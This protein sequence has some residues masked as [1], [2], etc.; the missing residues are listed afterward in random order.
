MSH[1]HFPELKAPG[2]F[3][4]AC[5]KKCSVMVTPGEENRRPEYDGGQ[6]NH[7]WVKSF[8]EYYLKKRRGDNLKLQSSA[9]HRDFETFFSWNGQETADTYNPTPSR[10]VAMI[11]TEV[12]R[13]LAMPSIATSFREILN[14]FECTV[15]SPDLDLRRIYESIEQKRTVAG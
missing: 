8:E 3:V 13:L 11:E 5:L 2:Y 15:R 6:L 12:A 7:Y 14:N 4:D 1:L 9:Y 10:L